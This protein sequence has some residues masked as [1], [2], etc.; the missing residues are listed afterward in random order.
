M[1]RTLKLE[2]RPYRLRLRVAVR[3]VTERVG[4]VVRLREKTL[5]AGAFAGADTEGGRIGLGEAAIVPEVGTETFEQAERALQR[6]P[7]RVDEL[8]ALSATPAA[9]H[10][11]ELA[12]LDLA[13][14]REGLPLA[15]MLAVGAAAELQV[16]ALLVSEGMA[17]LAREARR[18]VEDGFR[19]LKLKVGASDAYARA[20]V[21]RDAA[22]PEALLRLDANCV[23]TT[24]EALRQLL[25]LAPLGIELCEQPTRDLLGLESAAVTIAADELCV[26]E[27][28]AALERA[29]VVV[30]KPMALGGLLPAMRLAARA[31]A[32]GIRTMVTSSIDGAIARAGAAHLAAALLAHGPQPAAGL[33][34]GSLLLEDLC[35]DLL[36]PRGGRITIPAL[37][38]LGLSG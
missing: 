32:R 31:R 19:T 20:A 6:P 23:W 38:G 15:R 7:L 30:L 37:P 8:D 11:I 10:A 16:S 27:P 25:E 12:L 2:V 18:A 13:A 28:D 5:G 9:R 4:F 21:V 14:Q 17:E 26:S 1:R 36:A 33:A 22:G 34:T 35:E 24:E 29:R 3:G